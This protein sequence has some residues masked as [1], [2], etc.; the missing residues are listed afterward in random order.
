MKS[1][2]SGELGESLAAFKGA[3]LFCPQNLFEMQPTAQDIDSLEA[4]PFLKASVSS[5]KQG[6]PADLAKA[7]DVN[8]NISTLN[9]WKD[10][11]NDLPC[12]SAAAERV[13][14]IQPSSAEAVFF[15]SFRTYLA[16]CKMLHFQTT[17]K[18]P[19]CFNITSPSLICTSH[20][21]F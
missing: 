3:K 6:L 10:H 4:F 21:Y 18:H 2:D 15:L 7:A 16:H 20:F 17:F 12:W 19:Y 11:T 1:S 13:L 14:L 8:E 9:W 5:L